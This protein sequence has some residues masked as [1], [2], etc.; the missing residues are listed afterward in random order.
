MKNGVFAV[1][2]FFVHPLAPLLLFSVALGALLIAYVIGGVVPSETFDILASFTWSILL[3]L[4]VVADAPARVHSLLRFWVLLL[5]IFS[6]SS[7]RVLLL[8]SRM[9]RLLDVGCG[10]QYVDRAIH[11]CGFRRCIAVWVRPF[12]AV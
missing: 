7:S 4:W 2:K 12:H 5:C 1:R 11:Y 10:F 3:A 6:R 9:A 8:V